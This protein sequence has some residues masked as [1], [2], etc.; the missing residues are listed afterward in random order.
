MEKPMP[1]LKLQLYSNQLS[2]SRKGSEWIIN[3]WPTRA[4]IRYLLASIF[5]FVT[6]G[7]ILLLTIYSGVF[8]YRAG[9]VLTTLLS[10]SDLSSKSHGEVI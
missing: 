8:L 2:R 6:Q 3:L 1:N 5:Y 4:L 9:L 10:I 7:N